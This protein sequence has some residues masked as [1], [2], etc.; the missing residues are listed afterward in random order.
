MNL[1]SHSI[2]VDVPIGAAYGCWSR[3]ESFPHFMSGVRKV[4]TL[5]GGRSRW[6]TELGGVTREF[7]ARITDERPGER[8]AWE[9]VDGDLYHSGAVTFAAIDAGG[10]RVTV[11]IAW[12]PDGLIEKAAGVLGLDD[13]QIAVDVE[14]FK[15]HVEADSG[16]SLAY[17][18]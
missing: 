18:P 13:L 9:S 16:A 8:I 1:V 14:R 11:D 4:E 2:D 15:L 3:F 10:T 5:G 12:E 7:E 6:T 17:T